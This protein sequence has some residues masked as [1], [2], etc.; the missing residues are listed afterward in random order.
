M[1]YVVV[2]LII[3]V[4]MFIGASLVCRN[5]QDKYC[6]SN[7]FEVVVVSLLWGVMLPTT[8]VV[9]GICAANEKWQEWLKK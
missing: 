7:L 2:Y 9:F 4:L 5:H 8:A 1:I 6:D 3:A